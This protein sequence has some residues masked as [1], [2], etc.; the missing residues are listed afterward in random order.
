MVI[1]QDVENHILTLE[2]LQNKA[3]HSIVIDVMLNMSYVQIA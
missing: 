3:Y 1:V 2:C